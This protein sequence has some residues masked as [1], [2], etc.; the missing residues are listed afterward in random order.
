MA[1]GATSNQEEGEEQKQGKQKITEF[2]DF[3]FEDTSIETDLLDINIENEKWLD[4]P[5]SKR[6]H[7]AQSTMSSRIKD[8]DT[9][10]PSRR[11]TSSK[12]SFPKTSSWNTKAKITVSSNEKVQAKKVENLIKAAAESLKPASPFIKMQHVNNIVRNK[13]FQQ[14]KTVNNKGRK[15]KQKA[16]MSL[17]EEVEALKSS[18][19][20]ELKPLESSE[21]DSD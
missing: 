14:R 7:L 19:S 17:L 10:G 3:L 15:Q 12:Q 16:A 13:M 4:G 20:A 1:S 18:S 6:E 5:S 9:P 2:D 21:S 11:N 8:V